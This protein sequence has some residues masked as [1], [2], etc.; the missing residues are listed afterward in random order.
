MF[1]AGGR[2]APAQWEVG[3]IVWKA[4]AREMILRPVDAWGDDDGPRELHFLG[5]ETLFS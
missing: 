2:A 3:T 5:I 4:A 1:P